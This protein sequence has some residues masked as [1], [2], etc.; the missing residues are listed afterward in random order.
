MA[1][2]H[3]DIL[4]EPTPAFAELVEAHVAFCDGTAPAESCHRLPVSAL[5]T[6]DITIWVAREGDQLI[7]MGALKALSERDGEIK[8]MHTRAACRGRGAGRAILATI[9]REARSRGLTALWLETGTHP[10]FAGARA[11]YAA[12]GFTECPPFGAYVTDPHSLFLTLEL[13]TTKE[14]A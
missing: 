11:L 3:I 8:S 9:I 1:E 13:T 6:P 10:D 7:A 14:P 4:P 12:Y 2:L 5:F